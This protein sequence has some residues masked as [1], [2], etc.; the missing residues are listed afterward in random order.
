MDLVTYHRVYDIGTAAFGEGIPHRGVVG[1]ILYQLL[2]TI[3]LLRPEDSVELIDL[4][5]FRLQEL[6]L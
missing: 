1:F 5:P 4:R 3:L 2:E 6:K